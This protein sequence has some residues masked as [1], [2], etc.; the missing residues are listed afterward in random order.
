MPDRVDDED[1]FLCALRTL[2][3][4]ATPDGRTPITTRT[5]SKASTS[6]RIVFSTTEQAA[7]PGS[8]TQAPAQGE[9]FPAPGS[10]NRAPTQEDRAT[11]TSDNG[12]GDAEDNDNDSASSVHTGGSTRGEDGSEGT[13]NTDDDGD[14]APGA[15]DKVEEDSTVRD[16]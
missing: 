9:P 8:E 7:A 12:D 2:F 11:A 1:E 5:S 15:R 10:D 4:T 6:L 16:L 3:K 14:D 13:S